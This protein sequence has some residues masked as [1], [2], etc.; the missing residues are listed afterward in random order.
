MDDRTAFRQSMEAELHN[1]EGQLERWEAEG[2]GSSN[3]AQLQRE[4]QQMLTDLH[5]KRLRARQYLDQV[6]RSDDWQALKPKMERL[7]A[8]MATQIDT[9]KTRA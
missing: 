2:D 5:E 9:I 6:A 1:L 8:E 3:A 4:Q 7:W